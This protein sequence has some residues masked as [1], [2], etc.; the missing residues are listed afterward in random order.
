MHG[1]YPFCFT[2]YFFE[3]SLFY[4]RVCRVIFLFFFSSSSPYFLKTDFWAWTIPLATEWTPGSRE[5]SL[6]TLDSVAPS[7]IEKWIPSISRMDQSRGLGILL[8]VLEFEYK[9]C[10]CPWGTK[11]QNFEVENVQT[12]YNWKPIFH[13][14]LTITVYLYQYFMRE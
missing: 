4:V 12:V 2:F 6:T 14:Q 8:S 9:Y 1:L 3:G 13:L 10:F 5:D 11:L 7:E